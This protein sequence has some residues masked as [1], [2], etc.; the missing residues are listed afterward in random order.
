M[1][2]KLPAITISAV[3]AGIGLGGCSM[4]PDPRAQRG[5]AAITRYGCGTCHTV[6]GINS[7]RGLV[8]PPLTGLRDRGYIAGM[9]P[10]SR[11]NLAQWVRNPKAINPG[12]AMPSLGV[13]GPD[14]A[15][16]AAY[17]YSIP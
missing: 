8:G 6:A 3:L 10:N 9:L 4:Q 14:A 12:T 15:D 5:K 11:E 1:R 17:I 7:A 2:L 16:I 13:S